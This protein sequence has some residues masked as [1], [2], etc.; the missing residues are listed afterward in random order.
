MIPKI[1]D[2]VKNINK[3]RTAKTAVLTA[4]GQAGLDP[5]E[6]NFLLLCNKI[7]GSSHYN[8]Q[9]KITVVSPEDYKAWLADKPTVKQQ[10]QEAAAANEVP[11]VPVE[12]SES[13]MMEAPI[14]VLAN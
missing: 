1:A 3:L 12:A 7:C 11:A 14:V 10:A 8:M 6:F 2:K 13:T 9:M 5:Y 4:N